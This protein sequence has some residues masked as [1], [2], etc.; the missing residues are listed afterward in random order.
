MARQLVRGGEVPL[1]RQLQEDLLGRLAAGEF[2]D[3]FP[4]E[5]ALAEEYGISRQTVRQA[6]QRLRA[7]GVVTAM[8]GR[9]PRIAP[10][11]EILQPMGA[12]YS[13][14][15]SIEA[16][17]LDQRSD[18]RIFDTRADALVAERL[19][20]EAS[21]PLVYL[22]RLRLAGGEPLA[23]DRVW[24]RVEVG[25][26]LL[27]VDFTHTGLYRELAART[28]VR[29]DLGREYVYAV[30][31]TPAERGLLHCQEGVAAFSINRLSSATGKPVE[32][33]HTVVRGDRF[34][35]TAEFTAATGYR[36]ALR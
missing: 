2:A 7:D 35:L 5:L 17:G 14:F 34:A 22:E 1:W 31:P 30:M 23:L 25:T 27:G 20:L 15:A 13:L 26:P 21:A 4:G 11:T 8:R 6:L 29:L 10:A 9:Q 28:G 16:A 32:W 3:Q 33:R 24:L 36:L 19:G 18:V 12:L